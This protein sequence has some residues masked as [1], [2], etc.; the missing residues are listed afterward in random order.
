LLAA[1]AVFTI[2]RIF[3]QGYLAERIPS[4]NFVTEGDALIVAP[5]LLLVGIVL[6][7]ISAN[8]AISRYLKV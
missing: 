8:F 3:V 6:A 1:G 2:V 7:A 4:I 5:I